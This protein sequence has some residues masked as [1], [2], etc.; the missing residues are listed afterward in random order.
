MSHVE[1]QARLAGVPRVMAC[2][3]L[4]LA[5]IVACGSAERGD[6]YRGKTAE[7]D[8]GAGGASGGAMSGMAGS[9]SGGRASGGTGPGTGGR[10]P[11]PEV[12]VQC[13][14]EVCA[15]GGF[16]CWA[17][18]ANPGCRADGAECPGSQVHCDGPEDCSEGLVCCGELLPRQGASVWL[19]TE[20]RSDCD[21]V[22]VC[23]P[24]GPCP[25]EQQCEPSALLPAYR[26]CQ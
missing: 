4:G 3:A 25:S 10:D 6:L 1:R 19:G 11:G 16:C 9:A 17:E 23:G 20:C 7:A 15:E 21:G 12:R 2:A 18:G 24:A 5:W 13:G 8:A 26:I 14:T 22:V